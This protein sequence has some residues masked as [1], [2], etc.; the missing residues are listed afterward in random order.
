MPLQGETGQ[1]LHV[2]GPLQGG[3]GQTLSVKGPQATPVIGVPAAEQSG[4]G[5]P[6]ASCVTQERVSRAAPVVPVQGRVF[7]AASDR[8]A[9]QS[10]HG[11]PADS[12]TTRERV[13][14]AAPEKPTEDAMTVAAAAYA[15]NVGAVLQA[16]RKSEPM[17]SRRETHWARSSC[18]DPAFWSSPD[19]DLS[20]LAVVLQLETDSRD[21]HMQ[22]DAGCGS[23]FEF[24][25]QPSARTHH[26]SVLSGVDA[27][28]SDQ[29]ASSSSDSDS[30]S[31]SL[32]DWLPVEPGLVS[33]KPSHAEWEKVVAWMSFKATYKEPATVKPS[34]GKHRHQCNWPFYLQQPG[35]RRRNKNKKGAVP[36]QA[37]G[38]EAA[39]SAAG[40]ATVTVAAVEAVDPVVRPYPLLKYHGTVNGHKAVAMLDCGAADNFISAAAAKRWGLHTVPAVTPDGQPVTV[41]LADGS[42]KTGVRVTR[43]TIRVGTYSETSNF[44]VT[45]LA[46]QEVILGL[47]WLKQHNPRVDWIS[48]TLHFVFGG[49]EHYLKANS[50]DDGRG[51]EQRLCSISTVLG[52][53]R[54]KSGKQQVFLAIVKLTGVDT[55]PKAKGA[56]D[57][58]DILAKH[59]VVFSD[60]P[61]G[62]P[63]V[64]S[65]SHKIDLKP[66]SVPAT[67][68]LRRYSDL[69][70]DEMAKQLKELAEKGYIQDSVS[71][72]GAPVLFVKKKDGTWRMCIDYRRLNNMTIKNAYPLP[73]IDDL[74]DQLH[75]AKYF[76]SVDLR[77]GYHQVRMEPGDEPKTAFRT[78]FGHYEF[79]VMT[80][81]FTN[82][83]ATFQRVMNDVFRPYLR[84]F[85]LVYMDDILIF[86][87][88]A[89]EHRMH[90]DLV[91]QKLR[92]HQL[93]AKESKCAFGVTTINFLG[94]VV[95][96]EGITM[97]SRKIQAVKDWPAP[98]GT[99]AECRAAIRQFL[100][101]AGYYRRFIHHFADIAAPLTDLLADS[102]PWQ[103]GEAEVK[104]FEAL[105]GAMCSAPIFLSA[106]SSSMPYV[107]ETD[108]SQ[109]AIG[110]VLYQLSPT[111]KRHVVAYLSKRMKDPERRYEVHEQELLAVVTALK[112]WRHYLLGRHFKLYTDNQA[113]S[114]FLKQP[115]LSPRQARWLFTICEYDFD[116]YHHPGA[117]NVVA[118]MLSRRPDHAQPARTAAQLRHDCKQ[119]LHVSAINLGVSSLRCYR[120]SLFAVA[121]G[122]APS[123]G[124]EKGVTAEQDAEDD[125]WLSYVRQCAAKDEEYQFTWRRVQTGKAWDF[126]E[127][128]GLL[129]YAPTMDVKPLLYVPR[130]ARHKVLE[131]AHDSQGHLGRDKILEKV[132]RD[133]FWPSM[134]D[135]VATYVRS[136]PTCQTIKSTNKAKAGKLKPL[137]IPD[138]CWEEV[139]HDLITKLPRTADGHDCIVVFVDRLSK[140]IVL[141]PAEEKG[142]T[143]RKYADLFMENVFR[144]F[145]VP[146]ALISDRDPRFTSHLWQAL[147]ERLGTKLK[148]SSA[149]HPQTD[150]QTERA[151]RTVQDMLRAY[152][153][154]TSTDWDKH[155]LPAEFAYNNSV[156]ASTGFT[157]FYLTTGQHPHTPLS[158]LNPRT[159]DNG[160]WCLGAE[161]LIGQLQAN[162]AAARDALQQAQRR[163]KAAADKTRSDEPTYAVGQKV[164]VSTA[165]LNLSYTGGQS[166]KL[167]PRFLGPFPVKRQLNEV[168]Y[169]LEL[170]AHMKCHPVFHVSLLRAYNQS[171]EFPRPDREPP[172]VKIVDGQP[173]FAVEHVVNH[174]PRKATSHLQATHYTVKWEGYPSW[175]NTKEPAAVIMEDVP[176]LVAQYWSQQPSA[177]TPVQSQPQPQPR[178]QLRSPTRAPAEAAPAKRATPD[179]QPIRSSPRLASRK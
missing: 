4:M 34:A 150:G 153:S 84:K 32:H 130:D 57:L 61:P 29:P 59:K 144:H 62:L 163:Q 179:R 175:E 82:A 107:V 96:S 47:K 43:V 178:Q 35:Q 18:V 89:E 167:A 15:V 97:D 13:S 71:E 141:V 174:Y 16:D 173:Y 132:R 149:F 40:T 12:C 159:N 100:G 131:Q 79:K 106:P 83:P 156:Q 54:D 46:G 171:E 143:A 9:E 10:G 147:C 103:W 86:S 93:Y 109:H 19:V 152:V 115:S 75:G 116:I 33:I 3:R 165:N 166:P 114:Y 148:M 168:A 66:G 133:F 30:D 87:K 56:V 42:V 24:D 92:E 65:V 135:A 154:P 6:D 177:N 14:R 20:H 145:G 158:L 64:R 17:S 125:E 123:D 160:T 73:R 68:P 146:R 127:H 22:H 136:C 113:V 110:A 52:A 176:E 77:S 41:K 122:V 121:P 67:C 49:K 25:V 102:K 72:W 98:S 90:V 95:S 39:P 5:Q 126:I 134:A 140:R 26:I 21:G 2:S 161:E 69:N 48:S 45:D 28:R 60:L 8:V 117:K 74:L 55:A 44:I 58:S 120:L 31:G 85:V 50:A 38:T 104:A 7:R 155:L 112:E 138:R 124:G 37:Q 157:P 170:P 105:K 76:S 94:H 164:L 128:Q 63:P 151:N 88:T 129:Y 139:S 172:P 101:L 169:E 137:P 80:F 27:H 99:T 142:L 91:L 53:L 119:A 108:A 36:A 1:S 162:I 70:M 11:H 81:G 118:D 51:V 78:P 111:G 23:E